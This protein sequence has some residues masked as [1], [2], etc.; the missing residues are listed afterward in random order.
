[1]K[2]TLNNL[3][4]LQ[5][6]TTAVNTINTNNDAI[7]VAMDNTLS[8]DG[9]SPNQMNAAIDMNSNRIISLP[10]PVGTTEPVRLGDMPSF[11]TGGTFTPLPT[12]GT[13]N[14]VLKKNSNTNYDVGWGN[15]VGVTSVGLTMPADFNV[16]GSPVTS[17]GTLAVTLANAATGTGGLVRATSPALTTPNLGTPSAVVL[18]NATGL[19]PA[20]HA[21]QAAYT[22]LGNNTGSSA[23][24]TA[25]DIAGLTTKG[26]P[27]G[28]DYVILSDQ[29]A[30]GAWKKSTVSSLVG[31]TGVASI[32]G[33]TGSFTLGTGLTNST[34]D[35]RVS[36]PV[37]T[38]VLGADTNY[39]STSF[40]DTSLSV[41]QGTTGVF[42]V[43]CNVTVLLAASAIPYFK[44][45]DGTTVIA[46]AGFNGPAGGGRYSTTLSGIITNPAG[47][48]RL[49]I[50]ENNAST[51]TI[52]FNAT[53]AGKDSVLTVI[54]I[55]P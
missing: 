26:T 46:S 47:N 15:G 7:E 17:T 25:V 44:L 27:S 37:F 32:A 39:T 9:T 22:F 16:S 6:E 54:R 55:A 52:K 18:T 41:T 30:S 21:S 28:T 36:L 13:T 33:N 43:L 29:A 35:I 2:V 31:T 8:R 12:G 50:S 11:G 40:V 24:P 3:S 42:L 14:Q 48:I 38:S 53:G 34:N 49:A 51:T 5:N 4:N 23:S 45:Y 1:M 19:P 20:G 10:A